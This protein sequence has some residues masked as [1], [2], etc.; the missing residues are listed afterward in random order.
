MKCVIL[1]DSSWF[2]FK[3]GEKTATLFNLKG[4][5]SDPEQHCK[6]IGTVGEKARL[7]SNNKSLL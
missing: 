2:I 7:T 3:V 6:K 1:K 4:K 5:F